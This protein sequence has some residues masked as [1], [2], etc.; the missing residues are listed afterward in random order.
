MAL[1]GAVLPR[2]ARTAVGRWGTAGER[3]GGLAR[4][5]VACR[6]TTASRQGR[7]HPTPTPRTGIPAGRPGCAADSTAPCLPGEAAEC[8]R[9]ALSPGHPADPPAQGA[10]RPASQVPNPLMPLEAEYVRIVTP[11]RPAS[12]EP[13]CTRI[14]SIRLRAGRT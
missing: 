7:C 9:W 12:P 8:A 11:Q 13:V 2:R 5:V 1:L 3:R 4:P 14:V 6:G 10:A